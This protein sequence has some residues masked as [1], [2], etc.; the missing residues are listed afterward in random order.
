M[1]RGTQ[2][3]IEISNKTLRKKLKNVRRVVYTVGGG[4]IVTI[5]QTDL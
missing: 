5:M 1:G 4:K 2:Q 3:N